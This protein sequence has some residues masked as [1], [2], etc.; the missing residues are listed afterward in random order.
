VL[1]AA[2]IIG[3]HLRLSLHSGGTVFVPMFMMVFS[4]FAIALLFS[5]ALWSRVGVLLSALS[6]F[7]LIQPW[8]GGDV[9]DS[10]VVIKNIL[11]IIISI[12]VATAIIFGLSMVDPRKT[13]KLLL[14]LW[15]GLVFLA[16]IEVAFFKSIFDSAREFL[17]SG[18]GRGVYSAVHRDVNI[19]GRVRATA[20]ASEPSFLADTLSILTVM[21]FMLTRRFGTW[22]PWLLLAV[23]ILISFFAVPSFKMAFFVLALLVWVAWPQTRLQF[24]VVLFSVVCAL[25][26]TFISSDVI[27][28]LLEELGGEHLN[29]GSFYGRIGSAH[30]IGID[31]LSRQPFYGYGLG[32]REAVYPLIVDAWN[33]SGA[34]S[35]FPWYSN[36]TAEHLLSNGFWWMCIYLGI[37]G[38]IFFMLL[39]SRILREV[40]VQYPWRSMTCAAIVWYAGSAFVDPH[41]WFVVVAFSLGAL[42]F[43]CTQERKSQV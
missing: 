43:T 28:S 24:L 18:S 31:A 10:S 34:F 32:N 12:S 1:F 22:K 17:Y 41:S 35:L 25:G 20:L 13:R 8:L 11:Q 4:S 29:T 38:T 19:Y 5:S 3:A 23:M 27:I 39:M 37:V 42:K 16:F 9:N 2:Y 15:I 33:R 6:L 40:G 7:F 14:F 30:M 36:A 26:L 21:V